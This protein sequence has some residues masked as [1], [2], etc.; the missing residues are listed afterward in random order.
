MAPEEK[1]KRTFDIDSLEA[2]D[3]KILISRLLISCASLLQ[4]KSCLVLISCLV[5]IV[6]TYFYQ[7]LVQVCTFNFTVKGLE[8]VKAIFTPG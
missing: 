2:S 1:D 3:I 7:V 6:T 8:A 4:I 5:T